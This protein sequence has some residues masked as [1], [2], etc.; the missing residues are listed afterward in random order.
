M[1][2]NQLTLS[3]CSAQPETIAFN[4]V[5][6][7]H[8]NITKGTIL[9][10]FAVPAILLYSLQEFSPKPHPE[11]PFLTHLLFHQLIHLSLPQ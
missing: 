5:I 10:P 3:D 1:F 2:R 8:F 6:L 9:I 11:L 4:L 7:Q